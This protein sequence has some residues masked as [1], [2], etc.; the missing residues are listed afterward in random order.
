M[1]RPEPSDADIREADDLFSH[2][3]TYP[4]ENGMTRRTPCPSCAFV[5]SPESVRPEDVTIAALERAVA[6][7]DDFLC[8][9]ADAHGKVY[10]CAGWAARFG[11][12]SSTVRAKPVADA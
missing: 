8:H 5:T 9:C 3:T 11:A 2:D 10:T 6:D 1:P 4:P 12:D 7:Y